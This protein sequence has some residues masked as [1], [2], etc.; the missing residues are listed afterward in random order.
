MITRS[1]LSESFHTVSGGASSPAALPLEE[2]FTVPLVDESSAFAP[3][4]ELT[5]IV[6]DEEMRVATP[7]EQL[8]AVAAVKESIAAASAEGDGVDP[9]ERK[10]YPSVPDEYFGYTEA[11]WMKLKRYE[12]ILMSMPGKPTLTAASFFR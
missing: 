8:S 11:Q 9:E 5:A 12:I 3:T 6:P 4:E 10:K 1:R 2:S 7:I